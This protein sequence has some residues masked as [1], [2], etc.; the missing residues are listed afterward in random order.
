MAGIPALPQ[1]CPQ[2]DE[3]LA[4]HLAGAFLRLGFK[5]LVLVVGLMIELRASSPQLAGGG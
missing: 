5:S 2:R 1:R 3:G 4:D